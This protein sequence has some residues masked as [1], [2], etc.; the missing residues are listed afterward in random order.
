MT[1]AITSVYPEGDQM[2]YTVNVGDS[3]TFGCV[4]TGI[5]APGITW[6]RDG[7]EL[8][9]TSDNRVMLGNVSNPIDFVRMDDGEVISQVT[10]SLTLADAMDSDSAATY[11]CVASN[12]AMPGMVMMDF[13][14]VVQGMSYCN[15]M[16]IFV[17][18]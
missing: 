7:V 13:S 4:A 9:T 2:N 15:I 5:P 11:T 10:R 17:I 14:L 1:P 6:L 16:L 18:V 8:N 12:A 3:V